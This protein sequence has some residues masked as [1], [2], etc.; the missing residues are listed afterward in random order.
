MSD[1][2]A[3]YINEIK[4]NNPHSGYISACNIISDKIFLFM[5]TLIVIMVKTKS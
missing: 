3:N 5:S 4:H 2:S 1:F